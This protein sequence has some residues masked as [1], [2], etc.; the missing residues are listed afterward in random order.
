MGGR[1][2]SASILKEAAMSSGVK[3]LILSKGAKLSVE[4]QKSIGIKGA[5]KGN[6]KNM[7]SG[8]Y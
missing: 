7:K 4:S 3:R 5:K 2:N 6:P 8:G 1:G